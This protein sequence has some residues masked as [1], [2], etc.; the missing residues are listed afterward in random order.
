[1]KRAAPYIMIFP[2]LILAFGIIGYPIFDL[3]EM[4]LHGVNRFG[5]LRAFSGLDNFY[6]L[7][8]EPLFFGCLV[9]TLI[10]TFSI[11]IGTALLSIPIALILNEDRRYPQAPPR[12]NQSGSV[13]NFSLLLGS[14]DPHRLL[15]SCSLGTVDG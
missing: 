4:S 9:R 11:V 5:Q 13:R 8:Q 6:R 12:G 7:V 14:F 10:W 1:M 2:S 3:A 15:K